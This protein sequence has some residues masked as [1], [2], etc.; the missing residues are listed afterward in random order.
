MGQETGYAY[1]AAGNLIRKTDAGGQVTE[2]EYNHVGK[3]TQVRYF[4]ATDQAT[5]VKTVSYTYDAGGEPLELCGWNYL[6]TIRL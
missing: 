2:Y 3:V 4:S 6:S 1:D 5:P